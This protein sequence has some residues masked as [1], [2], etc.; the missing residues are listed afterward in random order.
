MESTRKKFFSHPF[1]L[2]I[3]AII[4]GFGVA[5]VIL[6]LAGFPPAESISTLVH[7]MVGRPHWST[8]WSEGPRTYRA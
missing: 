5:S 3:I 6:L 2:T 8:A 7:S 1:V 4:L